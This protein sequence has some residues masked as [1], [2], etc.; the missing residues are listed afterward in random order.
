[1]SK[2]KY[3]NFFEGEAVFDSERFVKELLSLCKKHNLINETVCTIQAIEGEVVT[4]KD[5]KHWIPNI[6]KY[7]HIGY[8]VC[9]HEYNDGLCEGI[10]YEWD[11]DD[12]CSRGER[13]DE[14]D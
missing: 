12:F 8:K 2:I 4:C 14:E 6:P 11:A 7:A 3:L 9:N 10:G 13:K 1:M 5:C